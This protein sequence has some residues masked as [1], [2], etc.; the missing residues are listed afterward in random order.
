VAT[1]ISEVCAFDPSTCSWKK[2]AYI[3]APKS[4]PGIVRM[5]DSKIMM[6]DEATAKGNCSCNTWIGV[7][8]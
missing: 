5:D 1:K 7:F 3:L 6:I 8:E 2:I 4:F